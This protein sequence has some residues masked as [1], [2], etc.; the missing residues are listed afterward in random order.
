MRM[1]LRRPQWLTRDFLLF[2]TGDTVSELGNQITLL[3]L[4]MTAILTLDAT[5]A[6]V[7]FIT[8]CT[9][10]PILVV[11]PLTGVW[12]DRRGSRSLMLVAHIARAVT[13]A[14]VPLLVWAS[15]LDLPTLA[16]IALLVGGCTAAFDVAYL[17]YVP[18]LVK[19]DDLV[20]ANSAI[21][22]SLSGAS[23]VGPGVAGVLIQ[24]VTA[25][26]AI[27]FDALSYLIAGGTLWAVRSREQ[28]KATPDASA[29]DELRAVARGTARDIGDGARRMV[30]DPVLR[31]L[32][33]VSASFNF[34]EQAV[35]TLFLL[36]AT[37]ELHLN[38]GAIGLVM[39]AAGVGSVVGALSSSWISRRLG[40][41]RALGGGMVVGSVSLALLPA[42]A[43]SGLWASIAFSAMFAFY[44]LGL[45]VFNIHTITVR[46]LRVESTM[47]GRVNAG[48]RTI[49]FGVIALGALAG[50]AAGGL[51]GFRLALAL[52]GTGLVLGA[53]AFIWSAAVRL[54]GDISQESTA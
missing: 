8:A 31:G 44:G 52:A 41:G 20:G 23:M 2:W 12:V 4:P 43:N 18:T 14:T 48:Y 25:P 33:A 24:I 53:V 21:E 17:S 1:R 32:V 11:S 49:T 28:A 39:A 40:F 16:V 15:M 30:Q 35:L 51:L 46:Q 38:V 36:Y 9:T 3:A 45:T 37:R 6:W 13:L 50:G 47:L 22:A 5:P 26:V 19:R 34:F 54:R 42:V 7:G 10:L 29:R 27:L